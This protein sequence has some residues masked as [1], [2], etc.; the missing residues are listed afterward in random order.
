MDYSRIATSKQKT[1][2]LPDAEDDRL[3]EGLRVPFDLDSMPG[4]NSVITQEIGKLKPKDLRMAIE[5]NIADKAKRADEQAKLSEKGGVANTLD[6]NSILS[7]ERM[8]FDTA[9][10]SKRQIREMAFLAD[11]DGVVSTEQEKG[12]RISNE[13]LRS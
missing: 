10:V 1:R 7:D 6:I 5:R 3:L 13:Y 2:Q 8:N 12:F 4:I 9:H 11:V